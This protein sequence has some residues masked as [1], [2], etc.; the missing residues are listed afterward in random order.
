MSV[1]SSSSWNLFHALNFNGHIGRPRMQVMRVGLIRS[2]TIQHSFK[3]IRAEILDIF[4][5]LSQ[6]MSKRKKMP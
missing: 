4:D 1:R 2:A 3:A 5:S 6:K